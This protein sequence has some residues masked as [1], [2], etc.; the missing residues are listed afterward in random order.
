MKIDGTHPVPSV[1][2]PYQVDPRQDLTIQ[3]TISLT[4]KINNPVE[5]GQLVFIQSGHERTF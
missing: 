4:L 3:V 2:R 1:H 5:I